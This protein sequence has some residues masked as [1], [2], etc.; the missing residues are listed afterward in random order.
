[1]D[2]LSSTNSTRE[3]FH[4]SLNST[5]KPTITFLHGKFCSHLDFAYVTPFLQDYHVLLV[6]LPGHSRSR[7][8]PFQ[9][10]DTVNRLAKLIEEHASNGKA[11]IVG[12][13]FGGF[14]ALE[15]ARLHPECVLSVFASGATPF[16][17]IQKW[18]AEHPYILYIVIVALVKWCPDWMYWRMCRKL[19]LKKHEELREEMKLIRERCYV[20]DMDS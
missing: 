5:S 14:L 2:R 19:R 10:V 12:L 20:V 9:L 7:E 17:G 1:M 6:D 11:N 8:I 4:L 15:L 3:I 16:R 18:L 13:S